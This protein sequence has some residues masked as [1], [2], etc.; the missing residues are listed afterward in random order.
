LTVWTANNKD[1]TARG[2]QLLP[3]GTLSQSYS[4]AAINGNTGGT[5][6]ISNMRTIDNFSLRGYRVT[7][8]TALSNLIGYISGNTIVVTHDNPG[9]AATVYIKVWGKR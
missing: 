6:T 7:G 4:I 5:L 9:E 3:S 2:T 1:K 8:P